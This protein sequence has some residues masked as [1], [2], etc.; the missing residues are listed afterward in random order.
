MSLIGNESCCHGC[1]GRN[2]PVWEACREGRTCVGP[3]DLCGA[4]EERDI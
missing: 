2:V 3:G 4:S 1:L